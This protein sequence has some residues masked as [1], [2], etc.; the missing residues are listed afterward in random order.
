MRG[1]YTKGKI[2]VN[3]KYTD[4]RPTYEGSSTHCCP[5]ECLVTLR[6][7][8]EDLPPLMARGGSIASGGEVPL[9][10]VLPRVESLKIVDHN[11]GSLWWTCNKILMIKH[12]TNEQIK[13][14]FEGPSADFSK[15]LTD[16]QGENPLY[17]EHRPII[18]RVAENYWLREITFRD[19]DIARERLD[20]IEVIHGDLRDL[21][22]KI[23]LLYISNA[24]EHQPFDGPP[25]NGLTQTVKSVVG[26]RGHIIGT[27]TKPAGCH[28]HQSV[29]E[30][31]SHSMS[32]LSWTYFRVQPKMEPCHYMPH[33]AEKILK[34]TRVD[35]Y[36]K[37]DIVVPL[38]LPPLYSKVFTYHMQHRRRTTAAQN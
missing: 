29:D 19:L 25:R 37:R 23:D 15:L 26:Y 17:S 27:N 34:T 21:G 14:L 18:S 1:D 13:A 8:L 10:V 11:Y 2:V 35:T 12:L 16:L 31:C 6:S 22:T 30:K 32:H 4:I 33:V 38:H 24:L 5:N 28:Q 20:Q 3:I 36:Y 9:T 7:L